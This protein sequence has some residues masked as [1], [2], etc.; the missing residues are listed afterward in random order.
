MKRGA[1]RYEI[2]YEYSSL[3]LCE[4]SLPKLYFEFKIFVHGEGIR[5]LIAENKNGEMDRQIV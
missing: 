4:E 2:Q 3:D 1:I 5:T